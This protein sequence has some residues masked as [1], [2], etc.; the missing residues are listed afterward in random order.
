MKN[1]GDLF[2]AP[3]YG[4]VLPQSF[5]ELVMTSLSWRTWRNLRQDGPRRAIFSRTGKSDAYHRPTSHMQSITLATDPGIVC[6]I[7]P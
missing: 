7:R 6:N 5:S 2:S 4:G 1:P 3:P